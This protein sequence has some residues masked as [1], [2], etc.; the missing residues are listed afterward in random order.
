MNR[1][2]LAPLVGGPRIIPASDAQLTISIP[3]QIERR[4]GREVVTLPGR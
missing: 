2:L 3:I 1:R 4:S